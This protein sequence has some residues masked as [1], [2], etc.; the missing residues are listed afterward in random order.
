[1]NKKLTSKIFSALWV[2]GLAS[3]EAFASSPVE[4]KT[5]TVTKADVSPE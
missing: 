3:A 4:A 1:M 2:F 5:L